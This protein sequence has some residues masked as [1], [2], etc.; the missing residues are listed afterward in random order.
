MAAEVEIDP[1]TFEDRREES[2]D[3]PLGWMAVTVTIDGFVLEH[4]QP[5]HPQPSGVRQVGIEPQQ[6]FGCQYIIRHEERSAV[7]VSYLERIV[8]LLVKSGWMSETGANRE[9][10]R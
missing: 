1:V 8:S 5:P 6:L 4:D 7:Y 3:L 9:T 2:S 10:V